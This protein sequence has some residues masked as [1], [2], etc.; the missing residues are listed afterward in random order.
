MANS[1][2]RYEPVWS[3]RLVD[4]LEGK[5]PPGRKARRSS[6]AM[7]G[8]SRRSAPEPSTAEEQQP[9]YARWEPDAELVGAQTR[10]IPTADRQKATISRAKLVIAGARPSQ[11][12][13]APGA[14]P[15]AGRE[16]ARPGP[17][18]TSQDSASLRR[19]AWAVVG[20]E[21]LRA[22][23]GGGNNAVVCAVGARA[24]RGGQR[25][26]SHAPCAEASE[27]QRRAELGCSNS[28]GPKALTGDQRLLRS[29][30]HLHLGSDTRQADGPLRQKYKHG[31]P[32]SEVLTVVR[33]KL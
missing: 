16:R 18:T 26:A 25:A 33:Q 1:V 24:S 22:R 21:R 2:G 6:G 30:N 8:G 27:A 20:R 19:G 4:T 5:L 3:R 28:R 12:H 10:S 15:G 23:R 29:G 14:G 32:G 31:H 11:R 13:R 17:T 7:L 9:C